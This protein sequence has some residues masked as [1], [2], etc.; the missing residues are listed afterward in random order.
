M[1][2]TQVKR[3]VVDNYRIGRYE[4]LP[5][6]LPDLR[7][8]RTFPQV[9]I[10]D[11]MNIPAEI[12]HIIHRFMRLYQIF[13]PFDRDAI[14]D[15]S[16]TDSANTA[17]TKIC[18]FK[19][20]PAKFHFRFS[21]CNYNFQSPAITVARTVPMHSVL[22]LSK[23]EFLKDHRGIFRSLGNYLTA[24]LLAPISPVTRNDWDDYCAFLETLDFS[25]CT[26]AGPFFIAA[27]LCACYEKV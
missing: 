17:V 13:Q 14:F 23:C 15:Q 22:S 8:L 25:R 12:T 18:R 6:T 16:R 3:S 26:H 27:R 21:F 5:Y 19:V 2:M 9:F 1:Q 20:K 7:K 24:A 11:P 4:Q 10:S